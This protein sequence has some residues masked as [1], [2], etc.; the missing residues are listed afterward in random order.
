[1]R[2]DKL[3]EDGIR[4]AGESPENHASAKPPR[5]TRAGA[6]RTCRKGRGKRRKDRNCSTTHGAA[7]RYNCLPFRL[8]HFIAD[9]AAN[10][11]TADRTQGASACN[12]MACHAANNG[13]CAD[14]DLLAGK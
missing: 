2:R 8:G 10:S 12:R 4:R 9:H 7:E 1:M 13:A 5:Y 6:V 3:K 11:G 14:A